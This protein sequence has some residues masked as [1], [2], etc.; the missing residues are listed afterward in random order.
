MMMRPTTGWALRAPVAARNFSGQ[1]AAPN[2]L[3]PPLIGMIP[4]SAPFLSGA[5]SINA[6]DGMVTPMPTNGILGSRVVLTASA[7]SAAT[8]PAG[9]PP[10]N[11]HAGD[12]M[13][14][15]ADAAAFSGEAGAP[16]RVYLPPAAR[17]SGVGP[18]GRLQFAD[19][20][21][22]DES[23]WIID[24]RDDLPESIEC[25]QHWSGI[26]ERK[27][28]AQI[29]EK[30]GAQKS[31]T[32]KKDSEIGLVKSSTEIGLQNR[33]MRKRKNRYRVVKAQ[34]NALR[35]LQKARRCDCG[36]KGIHWRWWRDRKITIKK[37]KNFI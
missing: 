16:A 3:S 37:N 17:A 25:K 32:Q 2:V 28:V 26:E 11:L 1:C 13:T 19:A 9:T 21:A 31:G 5:T 14:A 33:K 22:S 8:H 34:R 12:F 18:E 30:S 20:D 29:N 23:Q 10:V 7:F 4:S 27:K 35:G 36:P 15:I 6:A 24:F